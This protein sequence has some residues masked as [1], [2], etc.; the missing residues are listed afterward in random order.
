M[1]F[2]L[3]SFNHFYIEKHTYTLFPIDLKHSFSHR[4]GVML[5]HTQHKDFPKGLLRS[6]KALAEN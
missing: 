1:L 4:G 3:R 5:A 6:S 2:E